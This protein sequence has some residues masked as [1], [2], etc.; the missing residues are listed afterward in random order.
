[1]RWE[2]G[3]AVSPLN[4]ESRNSHLLRL[5]PPTN[6]SE[7]SKITYFRDGPNNDNRRHPPPHDPKRIHSRVKG[8]FFIVTR[9]STM[10]K[11]DIV[12]LS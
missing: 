4:G 1:M 8:P 12:V 10:H 5:I 9:A 11:R 2:L 3:Q 7:E 6:K